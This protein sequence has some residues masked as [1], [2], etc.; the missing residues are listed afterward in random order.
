MVMPSV[1]LSVYIFVVPF[2]HG[3]AVC[4]SMY[5]FVA[6]S[7]LC[8]LSACRLVCSPVT[9]ALLGAYMVQSELG[10][11]DVREFGHGVDYMRQFRFAPEQSD[12]LLDKV[13]QIHASL[14]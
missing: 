3:Y 7:W 11:Y 5:S 2:R 1:C 8:H 9:A 13:Q 4:L 12:Q 6:P 14:V 10:D